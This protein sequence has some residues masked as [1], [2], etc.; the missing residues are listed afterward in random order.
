MSGEFGDV[1]DLSP[2][3]VNSL[4][5]HDRAIVWR[6]KLMNEYQSGKTILLDRYTTSSLIYQS[7][8]IDDVEKKKE[9]IDYVCDFEYKKLG[10]KEPD[11]VLFLC[12]PFELA[13]K[14]REDRKK[15]NLIEDDIHE[16]DV[17]FMK[18]VYDSAL[19][20]ANYL[21]WKKIVCNNGDEM[22]PIEEINE[23]IMRACLDFGR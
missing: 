5:A 13:L 6:E 1:K 18:K 19:F 11:L 10:I 17:L 21:G 8:L 23:E 22:K 9:F 3:F 7:A 20:V 12:I 15:K 14:N 4:Y 16:R 2:Y